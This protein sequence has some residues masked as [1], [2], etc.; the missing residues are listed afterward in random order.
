MYNTYEDD[1]R[2]VAPYD[3]IRFH[4]VIINRRCL[5]ITK[6][7][8]DKTGTILNREESVKWASFQMGFSMSVDENYDYCIHK[9]LRT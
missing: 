4:G 5:L 9:N 2:N 7:S 6:D 1:C 8:E 3:K